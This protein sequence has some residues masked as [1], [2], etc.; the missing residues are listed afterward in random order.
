MKMPEV[1]KMTEF[2][3]SHY[4]VNEKKVKTGVTFTHVV[5]GET[6]KGTE[7]SSNVGPDD[8][9]EVMQDM[10]RDLNSQVGTYFEFRSA[11]P[12]TGKWHSIGNAECLKKFDDYLDHLREI[13]IDIKLATMKDYEKLIGEN[14]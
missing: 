7:I 8:V 4:V 1:W 5:T 12:D 9:D 10:R 11:F 6:K 2:T 13:R 3:D 14:S